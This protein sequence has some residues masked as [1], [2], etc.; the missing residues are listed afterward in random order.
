[1]IEPQPQQGFHL[2]EPGMCKAAHLR[3]VLSR[4]LRRGEGRRIV[5]V[6][7]NSSRTVEVLAADLNDDPWL[8]VPCKVFNNDQDHWLIVGEQISD[9]GCDLSNITYAI[10][11]DMPQNET[12]YLNHVPATGRTLTFM[13]PCDLA[14]AREQEC[15]CLRLFKSIAMDFF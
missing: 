6:F 2:I 5:Q 4:T 3:S 1:V 10:N 11:Y 7:C 8:Q 14:L 15:H 9:Q 12:S 13:T